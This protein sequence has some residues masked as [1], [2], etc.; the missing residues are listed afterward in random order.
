MEHGEG[1]VAGQADPTEGGEHQGADP[2]KPLV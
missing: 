1:A 2:F